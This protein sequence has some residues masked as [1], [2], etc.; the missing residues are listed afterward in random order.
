MSFAPFDIDLV[1]AQLQQVVRAGTLKSVGKTADF[2]TIK[3]LADFPA[4]CA[5]VVIARE[6]AKPNASTT[7]AQQDVSSQHVIATF[8]V[9]IAVRDY[10]AIER[11]G[12]VTDQLNSVLGAVRG[13]L[14]GWVPKL[15][16]A[17]PVQFVEGNTNDYDQ[18]TV[19][20]S[21]VYSIQH[22]ISQRNI[23]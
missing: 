9:I 19:L 3:K 13:A 6:K 20:W 10:R 1:V 12:Q 15:L 14:I 21:E 23:P 11:G 5:Y 16:G 17:R 8:G 2:A 18:A 4:P 7:G 22:T